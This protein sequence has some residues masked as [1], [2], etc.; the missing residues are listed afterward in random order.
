[1]R[2]LPTLS[3]Q[4]VGVG[5]PKT[6]WRSLA[7]AALIPEMAVSKRAARAS[8]RPPWRGES[9]M[10]LLGDAVDDVVGDEETSDVVVVTSMDMSLILGLVIDVRSRNSSIRTLK[11]AY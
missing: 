6:A 9:S 4:H 5:E 1:M 7:A 3:S 11:N 8:P 2:Q 10:G